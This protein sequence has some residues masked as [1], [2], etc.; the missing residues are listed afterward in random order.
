MLGIKSLFGQVSRSEVVWDKGRCTS[1]YWKPIATSSACKLWGVLTFWPTKYGKLSKKKTHFDTRHHMYPCAFLEVF[2]RYVKVESTNPLNI[3]WDLN[4]QHNGTSTTTLKWHLESLTIRIY[5]MLYIVTIDVI[6]Y[7][8][9]LLMYCD[10]Q[11][12]NLS[13]VGKIWDTPSI[14]ITL[15]DST[16]IV[17][18]IEYHV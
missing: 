18:D 3:T 12:T 13:F 16:Y 17:S 5:T 1:C 14:D 9:M 15:R 4:S 7:L 2:V 6:S 11:P 10:V 8:V